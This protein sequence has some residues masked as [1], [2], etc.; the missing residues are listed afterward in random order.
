MTEIETLDNQMKEHIKVCEQDIRDTE[1]DLIT[2]Q[3]ENAK[4]VKS[5][6]DN[7]IELKRKLRKK[8]EAREVF[9]GRYKPKKYTYPKKEVNENERRGSSTIQDDSKESPDATIPSAEGEQTVPPGS[10]NSTR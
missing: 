6:K 1:K 9:L 10:P 4:Y 8:K 5:T 7:I 3:E 2:K